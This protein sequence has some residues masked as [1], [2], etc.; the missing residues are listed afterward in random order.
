MAIALAIISPIASPAVADGDAPMPT[1]TPD[2]S[3]YPCP[4]PSYI[5]TSLV[6][7]KR[8]GD[9]EYA[10]TF[11]V[12]RGMT[13]FFAGYVYE[14]R[15]SSRKLIATAR[16]ADA[17][18]RNDKDGFATRILAFRA[19]QPIATYIFVSETY[20]HGG[21]SFKNVDVGRATLNGDR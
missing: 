16:G 7:L 8:R 5:G 12:P 19:E 21:C 11:S 6:S 14:V 15:D 4:I 18:A 20:P 1:P 3:I 13:N 2:F 10:L 17:E 9:D